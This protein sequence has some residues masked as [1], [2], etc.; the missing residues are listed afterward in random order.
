LHVRHG[1]VVGRDVG[2]AEVIDRLLWIAHDEELAG[3]EPRP[4]RVVARCGRRLLG[5]EEDDLVL[6]GIRVLKLVHQQ[7]AVLAGQLSAHGGM[8]GEQVARQTQQRVEREYASAS[9]LA[10]RALH[11]RSHELESASHELFINRP[12]RFE[13]SVGVLRTRRGLGLGLGPGGATVEQ[14]PAPSG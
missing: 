5:Q 13:Q 12:H 10:A 11:K 9:S 4:E 2:A 14:A 3:L 8:A 1:L 6:E 7:Q